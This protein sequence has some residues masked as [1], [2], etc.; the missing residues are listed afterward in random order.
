MPVNIYV[1]NFV[2]NDVNGATFADLDN[3]VLQKEFNITSWGLKKQV[4]AL[5]KVNCSVGR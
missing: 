3:E 4:Q 5:I 1:L 2:E